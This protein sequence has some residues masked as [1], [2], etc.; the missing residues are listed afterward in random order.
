MLLFPL[1]W[2]SCFVSRLPDALV[3]MLEAPGGFMIGIHIPEHRGYHTGNDTSHSAA[4]PSTPKKG[5]GPATFQSASG[6]FIQQLH[7]THPMVTGTYLVDLS[8]NGIHQYNGHQTCSMPIMWSP[9]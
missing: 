6:H 8:S 3:G 2:A 7:N 5:G 9:C 4:G 1:T